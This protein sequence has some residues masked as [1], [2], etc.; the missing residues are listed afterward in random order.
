MTNSRIDHTGCS[1]TA[2]PAGR[3]GCRE[4]RVRALR[5]AQQMFLDCDA[6]G[7]GWDEYYATVELY[8]GL[9]RVTLDE[10]YDIVERGPVIM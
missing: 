3:K 10:A 9:V 4:N 8:A 5:E 7:T 1:H 2:T 6:T